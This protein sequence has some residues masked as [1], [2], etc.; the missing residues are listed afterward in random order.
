MAPA[1]ASIAHLGEPPPDQ[2]DRSCS[3]R[4]HTEEQQAERDPKAARE[5]A[6]GGWDMR[7]SRTR[8][9]RRSSPRTRESSRPQP[10]ST[11][12]R[13]VAASLRPLPLEPG[14]L[15][16]DSVLDDHLRSLADRSVEPE[17]LALRSWIRSIRSIAGSTGVVSQGAEHGVVGC[18]KPLHFGSAVVTRWDVSHLDS[19]FRACSYDRRFE[20]LLL[21]DVESRQRVGDLHR[22]DAHGD[23]A[24]KEIEDIARVADSARPVVRVI[25]DAGNRPALRRWCCLV[26]AILAG[27][28]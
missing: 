10:S 26:A 21:A 28:R 20:L 5:W 6:V 4:S 8:L 23:H 27:R 2:G 3:V 15:R 24:G 9:A 25:H 16:V 1:T 11:W 18:E 17:Q 13:R 22:L 7:P 19:T 14:D 12:P